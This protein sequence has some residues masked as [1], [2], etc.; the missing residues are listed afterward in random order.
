M[1]AAGRTQAIYAVVSS[2]PGFEKLNDDE[3]AKVRQ[4]MQLIYGADLGYIVNNADI[5]P[6]TLQNPAGQV[7]STPTGPGATAAPANIIGKGLVR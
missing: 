6:G 5:L 7:V 2:Q 4:Q 1:T 3:R